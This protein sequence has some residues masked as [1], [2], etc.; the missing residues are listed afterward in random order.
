MLIS[1]PDALEEGA[2]HH[3]PASPQLFPS[4]GDVLRV[5]SFQL[6]CSRSDSLVRCGLTACSGVL[7]KHLKQA[8]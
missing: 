8:S 3:L 6:V 4:A 2:A 1:S 7:S 5:V